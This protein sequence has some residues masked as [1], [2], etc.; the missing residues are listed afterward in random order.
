[1]FQSKLR[2]HR[3]SKK[4]PADIFVSKTV[5]LVGIALLLIAIFFFW[6][7]SSRESNRYATSCAAEKTLHFTGFVSHYKTDVFAE[8]STFLLNDSIQVTIPR[9]AKQ[10]PLHDGDTVTKLAGQNTYIVT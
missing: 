4:H 5:K 8:K 7:S 10:V 1:M 6:R 3:Y 9:N 2:P